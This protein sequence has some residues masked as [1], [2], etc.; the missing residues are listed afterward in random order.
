MT[1]ECASFS[2]LPFRIP[3]GFKF[4]SM[5]WSPM[6]PV[7]MDPSDAFALASIPKSAIFALLLH[8]WHRKGYPY[9]RNSRLTTR[10]GLSAEGVVALT[11]PL[12][13]DSSE[14]IGVCQ[15]RF[16]GYDLPINKV[17]VINRT[18][19]K[20][21]LLHQNSFSALTAFLGLASPL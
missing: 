18:I 14:G 5:P 15:V 6:I 17:S 3:L 8:Q 2:E 9:R 21:K 1:Y 7:I 10:A 19:T 20:M 12:K 11:E 4:R 16:P 13:L